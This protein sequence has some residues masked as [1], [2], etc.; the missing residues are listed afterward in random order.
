MISSTFAKRATSTLLRQQPASLISNNNNVAFFSSSLR[1][2]ISS[3]STVPSNDDSKEAQVMSGKKA[4]SNILENLKD[5]VGSLD[6]AARKP[7]IAILLVGDKPDSKV[8]VDKKIAAAEKV[9]IIADLHHFSGAST[10]G[11]SLQDELVGKI[12]EL[13]ND[14]SIDGIMLQVPTLL[15]VD[16]DEVVSHIGAEKDVDCLNPS[17][18]H[19]CLTANHDSQQGAFVPPCPAGILDLIMEYGGSNLKGKHAVVVGSSANLG[20][21]VACLLERQGCRVTIVNV[22]GASKMKYHTSSADIVVSAVGKPNLITEDMVKPGAILVD[23]GISFDKNGKIV[24]DI[25]RAAKKDVSGMY[26]PVPN[27][28]GPMTVA[29]LMQNVVKSYEERISQQ[30]DDSNVYQE[31][32]VA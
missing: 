20:F 4:A 21:P 31:T 14:D 22:H 17:N 9:G 16:A 24:G 10:G 2:S 18:F 15:G 7:K 26:T 12:H 19:S 13:N 29:K 6:E 28:V 11:H 25:S 30:Q 1:C 5:T 27:G 32:L 23:A 8:Y 3:K